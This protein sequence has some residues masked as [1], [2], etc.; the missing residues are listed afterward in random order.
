MFFGT[1]DFAVPTLDALLGGEHPVVA[2]V[3]QPD[4]RRGRGRRTSPSPVA[5]RALEAGV[6]LLRPEQAG[7]P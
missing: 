6:P 3:S 4:R 1:P 2:V 7:T 5:E